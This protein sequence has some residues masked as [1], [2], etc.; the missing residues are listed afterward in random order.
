[1]LSTF[2]VTFFLRR[3]AQRSKLAAAGGTPIP[4]G[5]RT[6][7]EMLIVHINRQNPRRQ[8]HFVVGPPF[9]SHENADIQ[10]LFTSL[11]LVRRA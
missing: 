9:L 6:T 2:Q 7:F 5:I 3:S 8:L 1:V 4:F 11:M 10:A